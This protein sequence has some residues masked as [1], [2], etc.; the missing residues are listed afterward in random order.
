[1]VAS[2][3][4]S[5]TGGSFGSVVASAARATA[6][7]AATSGCRGQHAARCN[8][9]VVSIYRTKFSTRGDAYNKVMYLERG[10]TWDVCDEIVDERVIMVRKGCLSSLRGIKA[11][12]TGEAIRRRRVKGRQPVSRRIQHIAQYAWFH[13]FWARCLE[14]RLQ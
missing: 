11:I 13:V 2:P 7:P 4:A 8:K 1:M 9:C 10:K 14:G 6:E 5:G 12:T 3:G